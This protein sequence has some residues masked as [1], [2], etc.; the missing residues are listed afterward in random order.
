MLRS[1]AFRSV[2][3]MKKTK[4]SY[5]HLSLE[6]V[7]V[8]SDYATKCNKLGGLKN[9]N[10][11]SPG[12]GDY[13]SKFTVSTGLLPFENSERHSVPC[14]SPRFW[15]FSN[16]LWGSL[17]CVSIILISTFI[18]TRLFPCVA[19]CIQISFVYKDISYTGSR[20]HPVPVCP[21]LY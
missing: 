18:V 19:V 7:L 9:S 10:V 11:F 17:S 6:S 8:S 1:V 14:L 3:L 21:H 4:A 12:S 20:P 13:K 2:V 5:H 16:I 15:W